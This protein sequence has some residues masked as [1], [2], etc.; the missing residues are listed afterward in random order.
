MNEHE[1]VLKLND[2]G[3]EISNLKQRVRDCEDQQKTINELVCSVNRLAI[4]MENML[5]VQKTQGHRLSKLELLPGEDL[6]YYKRQIIG[7]VLTGIVG[8]LIGATLALILK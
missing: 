8:A 1:I 3:H 4:N 5:E 7:C 2:H 6:S